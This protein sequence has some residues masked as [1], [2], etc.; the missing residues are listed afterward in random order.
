MSHSAD[1][2]HDL[3]TRDAVFQHLL[4][5]GGSALRKCDGNAAV[6]ADIVRIDDIAVM[7]GDCL[8]ILREIVE[9]RDAVRQPAKLVGLN[10]AGLLIVIFKCHRAAGA[11]KLISAVDIDDDLHF[12]S[13]IRLIGVDIVAHIRKALYVCKRRRGNAELCA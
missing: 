8:V 9:F 1:G 10:D 11:V 12:R 3:N 2:R 7:Q 4:H 13:E 6:I 5:D